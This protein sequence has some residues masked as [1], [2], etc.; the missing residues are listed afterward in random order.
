[1]GRATRIPK[2]IEIILELAEVVNISIDEAAEITDKFTCTY[3][4]KV[5]R[6]DKWTERRTKEDEH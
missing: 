1:M 2:P 5:L 3:V 6:R 4:N